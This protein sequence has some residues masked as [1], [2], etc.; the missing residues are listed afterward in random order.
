[1][2][3]ILIF[4]DYKISHVIPTFSI[5]QRLKDYG[6][7]I[8]YIGPENILKKANEMGF[9]TYDLSNGGSGKTMDLIIS[10]A[11]DESINALNPK[12]ILATPHNPLEA[13]AI[14]FK[15]KIKVAF[16][17]G[18][19][20]MNIPYNEIDRSPFV[21]RVQE[22][23]QQKIKDA[24]PA[25]ILKMISYFEKLGIKI[26]RLDDFVAPC[27]TF[28]QIVTC[29]KE[30]HFE[31][32]PIRE[33][34]IYI[35]PTLI[36]HGLFQSNDW[37]KEEKIIRA[38]EKN[39]KIIYCSMG[40]WAEGINL[41]K[42]T[43]FFPRIIECMKHE[44]LADY[45]LLIASGSLYDSLKDLKHPPNVS[46]FKWL[47]QTTILKEAVLAIIHGGLGSIKECVDLKVPMLA[48]PLG[49]DQFDT[50]KMI[51]TQKLGTEL[52]ISKLSIDEFADLILDTVKNKTYREGLDRMNSIFNRDVSAQKEV[53]F[54]SQLIGKPQALAA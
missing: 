36:N 24:K 19:F 39:Q 33:N 54:V 48:S 21:Q 3:D 5:A 11:M 42:V 16:I 53:E 9:D 37:E 43:R 35:G 41:N 4:S 30:L 51:I 7:N 8:G 14:Y 1:M 23:A 44:A 12:L 20:P 50:T 10:G 46:V 34:E 49:I 2:T 31:E 15:Y 29:S 47:P 6:Y 40:S 25:D 45:H 32:I 38:R 26:N 28:G 27:S 18:H 17:W 13:L 22:F 52:E